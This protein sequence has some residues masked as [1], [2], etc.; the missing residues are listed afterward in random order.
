MVEHGRA[1]LVKLE[2]LGIAACKGKLTLMATG[3]AARMSMG[4]SKRKSM[5]PRAIG[6]AFYSIEGDEEKTVDMTLNQLGRALIRSVRRSVDVNLE[7][8]PAAGSKQTIRVRLSKKR[9]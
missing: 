2:C 8:A 7:L 5:H 6:T 9:S 1:A 3:A 4:N